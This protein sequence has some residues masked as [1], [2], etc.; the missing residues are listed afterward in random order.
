MLAIH[1]K[2]SETNEPWRNKIPSSELKSHLNRLD[3]FQHQELECHVGAWKQC[4]VAEGETRN[5]SERLMARLR[6]LP[7]S[8]RSLLSILGAEGGTGSTDT[9]P[10]QR[11]G[12]DAGV[13]QPDLVHRVPTPLWA[14]GKEEELE[15]SHAP[16]TAAVKR[17]PGSSHFSRE[18][19]YSGGTWLYSAVRTAP[20]GHGF[21]F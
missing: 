13:I 6:L 8:S 1:P 9:G 19:G 5:H 10:S 3:L 12:C 20:R 11:R 4:F 21:C 17:E 2:A 16:T 14:L 7:W 18:Q 15:W